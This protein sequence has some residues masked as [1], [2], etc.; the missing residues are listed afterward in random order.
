MHVS[1]SLSPSI[2]S[3]AIRS[4]KFYFILAVPVAFVIGDVV[5]AVLDRGG[6]R[7][8]SLW[9]CGEVRPI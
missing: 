6:L 1:P 5:P 4:Q 7:V 3:L 8:G 9:V 2:S